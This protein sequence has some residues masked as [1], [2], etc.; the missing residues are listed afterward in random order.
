MA[1]LNFSAPA[2]KPKIGFSIDSI[3]GDDSPAD[4]KPRVSAAAR[5]SPARSPRSPRSPGSPGRAAWSPLSRPRSPQRSRSPVWQ[6]GGPRSPPVDLDPAKLAAFH[7]LQSMQQL[8]SMRLHAPEPLH[9]AALR[10]PVP[11]LPGFGLAA[12]PLSLPR[13]AAAAGQPLPPAFGPPHLAAAAAGLP[14][15]TEYPLLPWLYSRQG[16]LFPSRFPGEWCRQLG[17]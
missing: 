5:V 9:P 7:H 6:R 10:T 8:H 16:R 4:E 13:P 15:Q 1:P 14:P 17:R 3:V 2:A 11:G 12:H